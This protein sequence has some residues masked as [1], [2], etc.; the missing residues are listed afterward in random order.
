MLT[1]ATTPA[2][3]IVTSTK[4]APRSF[5]ASRPI[6]QPAIPAATTAAGS[7]GQNDHSSRSVRSA[8]VYAPIPKNAAWP[9]ES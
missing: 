5:R 9:S 4:Y 3:E 2:N 8:E 6:A 1:S 7:A